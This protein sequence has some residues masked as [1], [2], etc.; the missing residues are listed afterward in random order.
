MPEFDSN[1][2]R[3]LLPI[4]Y[5]RLFPFKLMHRWLSYGND[6]TFSN[7]E[8]SFTLS[9]DVYIRFQSF[10]NQE[11]FR[12]ELMKKMPEKIDIGA[13]YSSKPKKSKDAFVSFQPVQK[14][15]VLDIDLTDYDDVRSCCSGATVCEKCWKFIGVA[16]T[17]LDAALR[18]DFGFEQLLWVF[19][20]RRGVHCWVCDE[21]ARSLDVSSRSA[22]VEY[23]QLIK[24][25]DEQ[26]KK[27]KIT[28]PHIHASILRALDTIE[29]YFEPICVDDQDMFSNDK[30][31]DVLPS[32]WK[33]TAVAST[34][35]W[36]S[37]QEKFREEK[38]KKKFQKY[39]EE[40]VKIQLCYPRLDANV[41]KGLNHLLKSPFCIH[42]KTGQVCVP[43]D[44]KKVFQFKINEV[45]TVTQLIEEIGRHDK[46]HEKS[47]GITDW[48][49]TTLAPYMSIFDSFVKGLA[50]QNMK[51][52]ASEVIK[53]EF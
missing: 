26:A 7:R 25:G 36:D 44:H 48:K 52:P 15:F 34:N 43:F 20:G 3:D 4:Y 16:V 8:F 31:L 49:K 51:T 9:G 45:P 35:R 30:I 33:K 21:V 28:G 22:V 23:L 11:E 24:G 38:K 41:S 42:P 40:E 12:K 18:D 19:S 13:V 47:M 27:V 53:M 37:I 10:D 5:N 32:E 1:C 46:D 14:E 17:I 29:D 39:T 50:K 6:E 2:L